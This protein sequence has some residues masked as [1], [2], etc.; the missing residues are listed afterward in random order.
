MYADLSFSEFDY[1]KNSNITRHT[2]PSLK[3][4]EYDY[5]E[6]NR[7]VARRYPLTP[8]LDTD[9]IY[10][11]GSRMTDADNTAS[12]VY[13]NYDALN[14]P[15]DVTQTLNTIDYT[16]AYDYDNQ[17]NRTQTIYPGGKNLEYV[18]DSNDRLDSIKQNAVNFVDYDYDPLG[19]KKQKSYLA[20]GLPLATYNYDMADQLTNL[21]NTVLPATAISQY[22]YPLYDNIGNRKQLDRTLGINPTET[23]N[24]DYNNIYE[25]TNVTGAQTNSYDYDNTGNR[26][27]ADSIDYTPN[28]LNQYT[29]VGGTAY[30]YDPNGNLTSDGTNTYTYDEQNRLTTFTDSI[31]TASYTYDPF[32]RRVSKTVDGITT[33]FIYDE[34][35]VIAEYDGTGTLTAEYIPGPTIDEILAME[36][37]GNIYYYHYDGLGS[38]TE[39]TDS[40]GAI[41]ENYEYDSFGYPSVT[42]SLIQNPYM[43]TGRRWD[44]ESGIYYYRAR[45]Y[46]PS[47]G[48]F[49]QRDPIGY[50]DHL[51]LYQYTGNNPIKWIDPFGLSRLSDEVM[52]KIREELVIQNMYQDYLS[53]KKSFPNFQKSE[54]GS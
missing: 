8:E 5:D 22:A 30:L 14:R 34:D 21:S 31:T 15:E 33:Y 41:I 18:Y 25:L 3:P 13:F 46:D 20:A 40:S 37:D 54:G 47:I 42:G 39:I 28:N 26:I 43:F 1:D 9:F 7:L 38:V 24:Y 12:Q 29:D 11:L 4:I 16:I 35:E 48:R 27:L 17:G 52:V 32:N 36:R 51:N 23:I 53:G 19:R 2:T 49:L 44:E 45:M 50:Y 6:L 10:D